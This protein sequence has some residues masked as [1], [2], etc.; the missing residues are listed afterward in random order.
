MVSKWDWKSLFMSLNVMLLVWQRLRRDLTAVLK[1]TAQNELGGKTVMYKLE[2]NDFENLEL[3][4][5]K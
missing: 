4:P 3:N 1:T 2:A 5:N